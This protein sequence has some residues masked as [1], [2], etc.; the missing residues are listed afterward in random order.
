VE[1]WEE[2]AGGWPAQEGENGDV[3]SRSPAYG[4]ATLGAEYALLGCVE[5]KAA[6]VAVERGD[7]AC[8]VRMEIECIRDV[9][10]YRTFV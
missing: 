10:K 1:L 7:M 8:H 2:R 4:A 6:G 5:S 3:F 9:G